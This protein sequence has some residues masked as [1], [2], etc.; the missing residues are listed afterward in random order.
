MNTGGRNIIEQPPGIRNVTVG[1]DDSSSGSYPANGGGPPLL[2]AEQLPIH[3][4]FRGLLNLLA[5]IPTNWYSTLGVHLC[6][7]VCGIYPTFELIM[8]L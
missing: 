2:T 3:L 8:I 6:L 5:K 7:G 1:K 4:A